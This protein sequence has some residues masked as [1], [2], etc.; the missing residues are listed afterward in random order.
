VFFVGRFRSQR[1]DLGLP[2][3]GKKD[4]QE[5]R[6]DLTIGMITQGLD[7][8]HPSMQPLS[9]G[10]FKQ[11]GWDVTDV[12]QAVYLSDAQTSLLFGD[13][14]RP[15]VKEMIVAKGYVEAELGEFAI[16]VA[17]G[18]VIQFAVKPDTLIVSPLESIL[19]I[20]VAV[21]T[22]SEPSLAQ[23]PS[24]EPFL[25][26]VEG[27]WG[28]LVAPSGDLAAYEEQRQERLRGYPEDM[29]S[30]WDA[31]G[32]PE[33]QAEPYAWDC[34]MIA[35]WGSDQE[36]ILYLLYHYPS[37]EIANADVDLVRMSLTET[38]S[39]QYLTRTWADLLNLES[40]EVQQT[41]LV[42]RATTGDRS[43]IGNAFDNRDYYGFLPTRTVPVAESDEGK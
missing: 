22:G 14:G 12:A 13:F 41:V 32:V 35:F 9:S 40:V 2:T 39:F 16:Y 34:M 19:S 38:P 30:I 18:D 4:S 31:L 7:W 17:D 36:T 10:A 15:E 20:F 27:A 28:A 24:V 8:I 43:F 11:W 33:I 1:T 29:P 23:H 3:V 37:Q 26:H 25:G 6:L 42:A 21:N 5:V